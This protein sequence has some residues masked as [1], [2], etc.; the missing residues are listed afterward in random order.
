[1]YFEIDRTLKI[2]AVNGY[3]PLPRLAGTITDCRGV[4]LLMTRDVLVF[5]GPWY[6][7]HSLFV[8]Q[9]PLGV[10][11][12]LVEITQLDGATALRL[13]V[14]LLNL[15]LS[16]MVLMVLFIASLPAA[17]EKG[18]GWV[19]SAIS[20]VAVVGLLFLYIWMVRRARLWF[21][22]LLRKG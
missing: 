12:G 2:G 8:R 5:A 15:R 4:V 10:Y 20:I 13:R 6:W 16:V 22:E 18:Y 11:Q 1:M 17:W 7:I 9:L 19:F 3:S 14:S 21:E